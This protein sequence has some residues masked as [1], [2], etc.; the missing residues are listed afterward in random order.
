MYF[1][2][3]GYS[4]KT[5]KNTGHYSK[6]NCCSKQYYSTKYVYLLTDRGREN[7]CLRALSVV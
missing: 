4:V 2:M 1:L 5:F 7:V 3:Y 6:T